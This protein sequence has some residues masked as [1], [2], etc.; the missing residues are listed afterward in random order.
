[1]APTV[2]TMATDVVLVFLFAITEHK[3][4]IGRRGKTALCG[5]TVSSEKK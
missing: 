4:L 2:A 3:V 5:S 1:M